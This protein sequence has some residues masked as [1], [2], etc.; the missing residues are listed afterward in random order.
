M[1]PVL[2][3]EATAI[4]RCAEGSVLADGGDAA[5]AIVRYEQAVELA[6]SLLALHLILANAQQLSG[7]VLAAR[8][9]LRR[10]L[11]SAD[12]SEA[13]T[14]FTLG[15]ALVDAGAGADAV[16]CFRR[17]RAE[18]PGDAAAAGVEVSSRFG[19]GRGPFGDEQG[20]HHEAAEHADGRPV[21]GLLGG[22]ADV[23]ASGHGGTGRQQHHQQGQLAC[24]VGYAA[25]LAT[26][27]RIS[28][29]IWSNSPLARRT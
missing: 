23:G 28:R 1:T 13:A 17:V 24:Q 15:K 14:E 12:R 21:G 2:S 20:Q 5:G 8:T 29:V 11:R 16:P 27:S 7:D 4:T 25:H 9:T 6:P 19:L 22:L 10:A 18:F 26:S 3:D